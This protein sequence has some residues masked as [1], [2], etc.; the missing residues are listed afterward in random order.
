MIFVLPE[1]LR[2]KLSEPIGTLVNEQGLLK[3]IQKEKNI[4]AVGDLVSYTLIKNNIKPIICIVDYILERKEYS[5]EMREKIKEYGKEHIKI[6]N[7][8]GII[9]DELWNAIDSAYKKL[10]DGPFLL[11]VD[12]EEDL[13]SLAAVY[14][15][16]PYVTVIYGLPNKGILVVKATK[17]HKRKAKEILDKM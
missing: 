7:P 16:P 9:T 8:P 4:V 6:K 13:A 15:A 5:H 3:L 12:G 1:Y 10:K 2:K 11:E 14:L 17:E